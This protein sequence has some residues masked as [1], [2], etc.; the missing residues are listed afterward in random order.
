MDLG[1]RDVGVKNQP[2]RLAAH[3][4]KRSIA[5]LGL[6]VLFVVATCAVL[7]RVGAD[8]VVV[9][10]YALLW[11][12]TVFVVAW[13]AVKRAPIVV[14]KI[15]ADGP[16]Q[17][18]W[19]LLAPCVLLA[20]VAALSGQLVLV[21]VIV[22]MGGVAGV[23][24]RARKIA[25]DLLRGAIELLDP[26]E[27]VLGDG[28]GLV[29]GE[30]GRGALRLIVA[31]DRRLLLAA[32][33]G[34]AAI[35]YPDVER[36]AIAFKQRGRMGELSLT[37]AGVDAVITSIVP[38]NLMSIATALRSHDVPADDPA[39]VSEAER[40][41]AQVRLA[42]A[43]PRQRLIDRAAMR[44]QDFDRGLWLLLGLAAATFYVNPFGVGLAATSDALPL[45]LL[46][47]VLAGVCGYVSRT[48]SS[49]AYIAPLNLLV[50]PA[51]FFADASAVIAVMLV[52]SGLAAIGLWVGSALRG[53]SPAGPAVPAARGSL[54]Y[55]LGG[56]GLIRISAM[57]LALMGGLVVTATA[58]GF[59]LT[60]VRLALEEAT[61][62]RLPVDGRSNLTGNAASVTYTPGPGLRELVRDQDFGAGPND[63]AHW[64]LRSKY[65]DG[66]NAVSLTHFIYD[67]PP[68][69]DPAAVAGFI[70]DR[71]GDHAGLA[72][73]PVSHT[74]RT[75][76]G[77]KAY[78]WNHG[79]D[80]G[81]WYFSA[82]F[83]Q[84]VHSV[85]L[86]CIAR[87]Q[88]DRFRRLCS[89]ALRSL[90]FHDR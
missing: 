34:S 3:F 64:E 36:F 87:S 89:E 60:S 68:L 28:F 42:P 75:V 72:G 88:E 41:W 5:L 81:V 14:V 15:T 47:P 48:R 20:L 6:A 70:A 61:A 31:T 73:F 63:G 37:A 54:R 4:G 57:L 90:E 43:P 79:S 27:A 44:T 18:T 21:P 33:D 50:A 66:Y 17:A 71:D 83:P 51:F 35:P 76:A 26:G 8:A 2:R 24:W 40:L 84:P 80:N 45:L 46:V 39:A 85:R 22:L 23:L 12:T 62:E 69:D 67:D 49:L 65:T 11:T 78:V 55:T 25:P 52:L 1:L 38:A 86:E 19:L 10:A 58:T 56:R 9:F 82:W 53:D 77:R 7:R 13:R 32:T 59:E 16:N 29:K 30:R 74:E